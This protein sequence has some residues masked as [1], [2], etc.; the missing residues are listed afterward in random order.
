MDL[1]DKSDSCLNIMLV[2]GKVSLFTPSGVDLSQFDEMVKRARVVMQEQEIESLRSRL[3]EIENS[4]SKDKGEVEKPRLLEKSSRNGKAIGKYDP[5]WKPSGDEVDLSICNK[6]L[7]SMMRANGA[8]DATIFERLRPKDQGG[9]PLK[10]RD[11]PNKTGAAG[12]PVWDENPTGEW[13]GQPTGVWN[14]QPV[15]NGDSVYSGHSEQ[16]VS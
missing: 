8:D 16:A 6:E 4:A 11:D 2:G 12:G 9:R 14:G 7:V 1:S 15:N 3:E 5:D 10:L 13:N